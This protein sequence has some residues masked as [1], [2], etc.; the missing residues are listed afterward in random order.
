M[1]TAV[2]PRSPAH[3][4]D[5]LEDLA[6]AAVHAV[7]IAERQH[8]LRPAG[9]PRIVREMNDVHVRV[10]RRRSPSTQS[11]SVLCVSAVSTFVVVKSSTSPS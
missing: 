6:V 1:T 9:R 11:S 4:A 7:E 2:A 5:A 8:R 3:A 10:H